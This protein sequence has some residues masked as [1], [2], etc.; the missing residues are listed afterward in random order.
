MRTSDDTVYLFDSVEGAAYNSNIWIQSLTSFT[1]SQ[2]A[3]TGIPFNAG[4][5]VTTGQGAMLYLTARSR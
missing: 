5:S 1:M 2:A 3:A 4:S